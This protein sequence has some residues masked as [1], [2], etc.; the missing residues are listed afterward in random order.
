[1]FPHMASHVKDRVLVRDWSGLTLAYGMVR[2]MSTAVLEL[3]I[4]LVITCITLHYLSFSALTLSVG[5]QEG[6]TACKKLSGGMLT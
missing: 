2:V 1:V 4:S 3:G 5:R 6:H